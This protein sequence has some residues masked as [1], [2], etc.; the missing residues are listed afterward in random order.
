MIYKTPLIEED[1]KFCFDVSICTIKFNY[2]RKQKIYC[3]SP[4]LKRDIS[5]E[6][7]YLNFNL[8]E[9]ESNKKILCEYQY[10]CELNP[11]HTFKNKNLSPNNIYSGQSINFETNSKEIKVEKT[12]VKI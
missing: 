3:L 5:Y 12:E 6:Q 2:F 4:K 9:E 7:V 1:E 10:Y 11:I 8:L